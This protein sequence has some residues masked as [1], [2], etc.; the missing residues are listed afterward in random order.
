MVVLYLKKGSFW[1]NLSDFEDIAEDYQ[2]EVQ[3]IKV[4]VSA[5]PE[6]V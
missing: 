1:W 5:C 4:D 2:N 3:F 6:I